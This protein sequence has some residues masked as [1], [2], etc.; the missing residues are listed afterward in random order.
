MC[1]I[2]NIWEHQWTKL[3][4]KSHTVLQTVF[5][6]EC[7]KTLPTW[8]P[9]HPFISTPCNLI[10]RNIPT[11]I[12]TF[13]GKAACTEIFIP[14]ALSELC[15]VWQVCC[16][17]S[18]AEYLLLPT[19]P[20]TMEPKKIIRENTV[21]AQLSKTVS[22]LNWILFCDRYQNPIDFTHAWPLR[23]SQTLSGTQL[24]L[25]VWCYACRI[26]TQHYDAQ[27]SLPLL[28][29]H[30]HGLSVSTTQTFASWTSSDPLPYFSKFSVRL[31][32]IRTCNM[33][34]IQCVSFISV[35]S[36]AAVTGCP[37]DM[38]S[39]IIK[40]LCLVRQYQERPW[41]FRLEAA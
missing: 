40:L 18:N 27:I 34:D 15:M 11:N 35:L 23:L 38:T 8:R 28:T 19:I 14:N 3:W 12:H 4:V 9:H 22:G 16:V 7:V 39:Y 1:D 20:T 21:H 6:M 30:A 36:I 33:N 5:Q 41:I 24:V 32:G 31:Y 10:Y 25:H 37:G 13:N 26:N 17:W 29:A 2:L